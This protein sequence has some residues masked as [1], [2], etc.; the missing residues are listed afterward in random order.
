MNA[1]T[2]TLIYLITHVPAP[3]SLHPGYPRP[4]KLVIRVKRPGDPPLHAARRSSLRMAAWTLQPRAATSNP[5]GQLPDRQNDAYACAR[6]SG[7]RPMQARERGPIDR[8]HRGITRE[9]SLRTRIGTCK[10]SA[11]ATARGSLQTVIRVL[12]VMAALAVAA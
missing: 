11:Q 3:R 9:L 5:Y 6:E 1:F 10:L 7:R 12:L 2:F 8:N 4:G